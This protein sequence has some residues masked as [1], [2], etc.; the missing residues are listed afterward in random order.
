MQ[1]WLVWN[2]Q[3]SGP[4]GSVEIAGMW[5]HALVDSGVLKL[6]RTNPR[7]LGSRR[8]KQMK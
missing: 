4:A 2:S 3:S 1:P 6:K 8:I 5:H 7:M